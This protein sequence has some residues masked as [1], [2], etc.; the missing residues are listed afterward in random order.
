MA[1]TETGQTDGN[2]PPQVSGADVSWCKTTGADGSCVYLYHLRI[3]LMNQCTAVVGKYCLTGK[4]PLSVTQNLNGKGES[5][6]PAP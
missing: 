1:G 6:L 4:I 3:W 5:S 2:F